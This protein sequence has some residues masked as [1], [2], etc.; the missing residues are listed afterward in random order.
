[1]YIKLN[2]HTEL[3]VLFFRFIKKNWSHS[4]DHGLKTTD[5]LLRIPIT[6]NGMLKISR[7]QLS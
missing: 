4:A 6:S 1:M 3:L 5:W 7:V 2:F